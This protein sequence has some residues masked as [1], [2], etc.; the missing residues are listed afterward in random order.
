MKDRHRHLAMVTIAIAL[1]LACRG[2]QPATKVDPAG[3]LAP[4]YDAIGVA[5]SS[6]PQVF[7]GQD[8]WEYINGGAELYH[9]YGFIEV[10]T[11]DYQKGETEMVVDIYRFDSAVNAYG[12]YSMMRPDET[13]LARYGVE[14]F[15]SPAKIE[16]VKGDLLVRVIGFDESDE[17]GLALINLADEIDKQLPGGKQ[18]PSAFDLFPPSLAVRGSDKYYVEAFLGQSFL[19]G[20]YTRDFQLDTNRITLFLCEHEAGVKLLEWSRLAEEMGS[21]GDVPDDLAFDEGKAFAV[22]NSF[23][24]RIVVGLCAGR[25]VGMVGY[26]QDHHSLLSDW[27]DGLK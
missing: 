16:F 21:F 2:E 15:I 8:L 9:K 24:G 4:S 3:Y 5:R 7:V 6:P 10:A 11:A 23:Y 20:V 22:D 17:T 19:T 26:T 12:L 27:L 14:G 18:P 13:D 25:M 1:S